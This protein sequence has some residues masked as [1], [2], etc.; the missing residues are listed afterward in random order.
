M[1]TDL[2]NLYFVVLAHLADYGIGAET[3]ISSIFNT[4]VF[5]AGESDLDTYREQVGEIVKILD[6]MKNNGHI[7]Y[8]SSIPT[9]NI[10]AIYYGDGLFSA[11]ITQAGLDYYYAHILRS[12]TIK[13]LISKKPYNIAT[14]TIAIVAICGT[15]GTGV[16]FTNQNRDLSQ[17]IDSLTQEVKSKAPA[18]STIATQE[19]P[20]SV[21]RK[22]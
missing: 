17:R 6:V 2:K 16:Y 11:S 22:K 4:R 1:G 20:D 18:Q 5:N 7:N 14:W 8:S 15:I 10:T 21:L 3:D 9:N 12:A 13:S 19:T